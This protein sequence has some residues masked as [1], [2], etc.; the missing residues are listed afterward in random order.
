MNQFLQRGWQPTR[1]RLSKAWHGRAGIIVACV[2]KELFIKAKHRLITCAQGHTEISALNHSCTL[3]STLNF[4]CTCCKS[5]HINPTENH[6]A[7]VKY[8]ISDVF[9]CLKTTRLPSSLMLYNLN[10][11]SGY[12]IANGK[13]SV[14]NNHKYP[15]LFLY[16]FVLGGFMQTLNILKLMTSGVKGPC[17][18][19]SW[20]TLNKMY[21]SNQ[22]V[23][24]EGF[25]V[26]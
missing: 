23:Q 3:F 25:I 10:M 24:D 18:F 2:S 21:W 14:V 7:M 8:F 9:K 5:L 22:A 1:L 6:S 20:L 16:K 15:S 13:Y 11:S 19:Y 4:K 12:V 26:T 17:I